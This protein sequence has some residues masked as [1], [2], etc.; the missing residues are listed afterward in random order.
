M[1]KKIKN[2]PGWLGL[3]EDRESFVYLPDRA[4]IVREIFDL[5]ISGFGGYAI[6][7]LL[8]QK[9]IPGFGSSK[10]WDQSTIHNMLSSRQRWA[11]TR[12]RKQ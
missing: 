12:E 2:A 11:S 5:S 1:A 3:A 10:R 9:K 8:N 4:K 6:A 7:N